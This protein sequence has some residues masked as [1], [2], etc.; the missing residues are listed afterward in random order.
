MEEKPCPF[1]QLPPERIWESNK[2]AILVRDDYP[3]TA[4]HSLILPRRHI[5]SIFDATEAELRALWQLIQRGRTTINRAYA[6]AAYNLGVNDGPEAG[7]TVPHLHVH[8][9]PR[10]PGDSVDP[11]G[12]IRWILPERASY[13]N[14]DEPWHR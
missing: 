7:Q 1:C 14:H 6:P 8:L 9:I 12:G 4:G 3:L 2:A 5:G 10:Y 13:W 11:R